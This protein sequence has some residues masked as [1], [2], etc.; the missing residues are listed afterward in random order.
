M[1][2]F[3]LTLF[4]LISLIACEADTPTI[5]AT[6]DL[7]RDTQENLDAPAPI[8]W[9]EVPATSLPLAEDP[10]GDWY[11]GDLH[12]HT[13]GASNDTGGDSFPEDIKAKALERGLYFVVLTDHSNST[14]SDVDTTDE[15]PAKFNQGP[16]FPYWDEA[17]ALSEPGVFI[18]VDGNEMSPVAAGDPPS[19]PTGHIGCIPPSKSTF[20]RS[21]APFIDRPRGAVDGGNVLQQAL[22]R[23]CFT[24]LNH[25]Y[26]L[27]LWTGFDW[28]GG[29]PSDGWGYNAI[30]VWNG[31]FGFGPED[32]QGRA[33]WKCDLL[34]GR[35]VTAVGG[36]DNHRVNIDA[37]GENANP[38][39]GWPT[40]RVFSK[41][42]S[43]EAIVEGLRNGLVSI[44]QGQ[45]RLFIDGYDETFQRAEDNST[46][47][48]RIRAKADPQVGG[49][50]PNLVVSIATSCDDTRPLA[51]SVEEET[52]F[53][54]P[55]T[56]GEEL[57]VV[58]PFD[59]RT[60]VVTA[61]LTKRFYRYHAFSRAIVIP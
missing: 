20:D 21:D 60:G 56:P 57:D 17:N 55:M 53:R 32:E 43:W 13:T 1:D 10:T 29:N 30:E 6:P 25:P 26:S 51:P 46:R 9:M 45:S 3:V 44:D 2:R 39:L 4:V 61:S 35:P 33:A 7:S 54:A 28:T 8:D 5:D 40:T 48:I 12:V 18:M 50:P 37:P 11:P 14:G 47:F 27:A 31:T 42:A 52:L 15:D 23:G 22:D 38:A 16:E 58:I 34:A 36:S 49:F 24:I 19:I 41:D 59:G